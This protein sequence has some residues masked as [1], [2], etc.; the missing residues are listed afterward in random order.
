V[1]TFPPQPVTFTLDEI[2]AAILATHPTVF[3]SAYRA[4]P[5]FTTGANTMRVL[6]A[7]DVVRRLRESRAGQA[8]AQTGEHL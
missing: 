8:R 5:D 7:K 4:G 1:T 2:G 6:V 3:E